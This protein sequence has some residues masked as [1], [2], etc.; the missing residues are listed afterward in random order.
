MSLWF[1]I[2]SNPFP[3][4]SFFGFLAP[5]LQKFQFTCNSILFFDKVCLKTFQ[6]AG[7]LSSVRIF[8]SDWKWQMFAKKLQLLWL[9]LLCNGK[10]LLWNSWE[11]SHRFWREDHKSK[12]HTQMLKFCRA[13]LLLIQKP[14][15]NVLVKMFLSF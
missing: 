12:L 3:T 14:C 4:P 6:G 5:P 8:G 9:H 1:Q 10:K 11:I 2:I 15:N 13:K 7:I